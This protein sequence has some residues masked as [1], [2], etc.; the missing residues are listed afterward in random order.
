M[1]TSSTSLE[2]S[3]II[4]LIALSITA[5]RTFNSYQSALDRAYGDFVSDVN[6]TQDKI[7]ENLNADAQL[8]QSATALFAASD[9][10]TR[11]DWHLF[12]EHSKTDKTPNHELG[13]GYVMNIAKNKIR[14]HIEKIRKEGFPD[15]DVSTEGVR[16]YYSPV[17]FLEPFT[18]ANLKV[19]GYDNMLEPVRRSALEQARDSNMITLSGK[20][21]LRQETDTNLQ[22]G[23][24]IFAPVYKNGMPVNTVWQRRAAIKG[25]AY[26]AYRMSDLMAY[27]FKSWWLMGEDKIRLQIYDD[28]ISSQSMLYDSYKPGTISSND[29]HSLSI[30]EVSYL[31]GRKWMLHFT[32]PHPQ[33]FF[34]DTFVLINLI[35]GIAISFILFLL[36]LSLY[37]TGEKARKIAGHLT[38][39]LKESK[40]RLELVLKGSNDGPWD[41]DLLTQTPYYYPQWWK[42][43]GYV[44][45][46]FLYEGK[47]P[48][49]KLVHPDDI[50]KADLLLK[51]A[52]AGGEEGYEIE[53]RLLHKNGSYL[54]MLSRGFITRDGNGVPV[55]VSGSD[56]DLTER[57]KAENALR[58]SEEKF[59]LIT[60]N[61]IDVIWVLNYN[62]KKITYISPSVLNLHGFTVEEAMDQSIDLIETGNSDFKQLIDSIPEHIKIALEPKNTDKSFL[63][64]IQLPCKNGDLIWVEIST[65]YRINSDGDN[66]ILG[67]TRNIEGRKRLEAEILEKNKLLMELNATKDKFFSIIAHDL[68]NPFNT[69]LGFSELLLSN[70]DKIDHEKIVKYVTTI[71]STGKNTYKLL[72]NLLVWSRSQAGIIEFNPEDLMIEKLIAEVIDLSENSSKSKNITISYEIS[73]S[74][75]AFADHNMVSTVLRNL[76]SNAIKFTNR[77]GTIQ[78]KALRQNNK[79]QITVSD[80]GIGIDDKRKKN[81]F[82]INEKM[83]TSGTENEQ[84]T[85][86]GLV[87]CQ[88]F[89]TKHNEKI[90]IES[91][92]G[93]GSDFIF[94]LPLSMA[95]K[96]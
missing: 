83:G 41:L 66:E 58:L 8:L 77:N 75:I 63:S 43:L 3:L 50:G 7:S 86:L 68:R 51:A 14:Q 81:L 9:T 70:I 87:L 13:V 82:G 46:E 73:D 17:V 12:V 74:L 71:H 45:D 78:L 79:V 72:E 94:T 33:T 11:E 56:R 69:I 55:R 88:E 90:W 64:Q 48:W 38:L 57:K 35:G 62:Q 29:N 52:L 37:S 32:Q 47:D 21:I 16:Q 67:V 27:I 96:L 59:R 60:E 65:R 4:L 76:V 19:F 6:D 25:W 24:L 89:I 31:Y 61:V 91:Q 95:E 42:Q 39:E 26:Q 85:G 18:G 40:E 20:I 80:S 34:T 93:K 15:Y 5:L 54:S 28:H 30:T 22:T 44:A 53:Y 1:R 36:V 10:V 84:G 2:K 92:V 23:V 49:R